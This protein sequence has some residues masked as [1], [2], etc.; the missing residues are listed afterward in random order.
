MTIAEKIAARKALG[1]TS[2]EYN[3]HL[4]AEVIKAGCQKLNREFN[5][6]AADR[7]MIQALKSNN[8]RAI[9]AIMD[10]TV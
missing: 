7:E 3:A 10:R 9:R 6:T 4:E 8:I 2:A 5:H 1:M